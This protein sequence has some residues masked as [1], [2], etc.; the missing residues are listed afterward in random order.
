MQIILGDNFVFEPASATNIAVATE[1]IGS[2][3]FVAV[4]GFK[5]FI[6]ISKLYEKRKEVPQEGKVGY[7]RRAFVEDITTR[8]T[9]AL[10]ITTLGVT[11]AILGTILF[12]AIGPVA[13]LVAGVLYHS[14]CHITGNIL[15][16]LVGQNISRGF[17]N[18]IMNDCS[19]SLGQLKRGD[20]IVV[21]GNPLHPRCHCIVSSINKE[22]K[23]IH[24]IRF[25]YKLGVVRE[26]LSY[27]EKH[28]P[29][30]MLYGE[31]TE[32]FSPKEII[33]RACFALL[34]YNKRY[35]L[36]WRNCKHF[37]YAI[38]KKT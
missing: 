7:S 19:V 38:I 4:E 24:V 29:R 9:K 32:T 21:F 20:H 17:T 23:E 11:G 8:I 5:C 13:A 36:I 10:I 34:C 31:T 22:S 33:N 25:R 2:A 6:D 12:P 26:V 35:D 3:V 27:D 30:K 14:V 28:P 37:A 18:L 1:A 15:G 16:E